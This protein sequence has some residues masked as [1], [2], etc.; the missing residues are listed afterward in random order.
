MKIEL[1]NIRHFYALSEETN[2]FSAKLY[3][4]DVLTADCSDTGKGGCIDI[5]AVK[6]R[7]QLLEQAEAYTKS[8]PAVKTEFDFELDM[9]LELFIGRLVGSD[10]I[11]KEFRKAL[12]KLQSNNLVFGKSKTQLQYTWFTAKDKKKAAVSF[13]LSHPKTRQILS[14]RIAKL[15]E[16]GF[17]IFNT[18]I[19]ESP[20]GVNRQ[21]KVF[22]GGNL[23]F[24]SLWTEAGCKQGNYGGGVCIAKQS[25]ATIRIPI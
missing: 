23:K 18:N 25:P 20:E 1:K 2:A 4:N 11:E 24:A 8:L 14:D 16:E 21:A 19:P 17:R 7:E 15:K 12:K 10:I 22:S 3:V 13:M 6:G 9:D 5:R